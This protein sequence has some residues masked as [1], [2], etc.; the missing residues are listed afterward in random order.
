[1]DANTKYHP[2]FNSDSSETV[3]YNT[4]LFPAYVAYGLLSTYPDYSYSSHWHK[5][6]EFILVKK[7]T[8]T[9]NVNGRLIE[10]DENSGI[11]VNS[12]QLHYGF[13]AEHHE[14]E[15]VC[16]LLSPELLQI[17]DWFYQNF[18]EPFIENS[19]Y[20]Y[21]Y[22]NRSGWMASIM[23]KLDKIYDSFGKAPAKP[24]SYF[25]LLN[26]YFMIMETLYENLDIENQTQK[27]ESS[28]LSSLRSMMTY[29]EEH[30]MERIT[31]TDI[32]LSGACCK[33]KCSL[34]F[35]KY[36]RDTPIIYTT[37]LRLEKSLSTLLGSN[38]NISTI[39]YEYGFNGASYY[40]E[41]FKKYY[42]MPPLIYKKNRMEGNKESSE[43][44]K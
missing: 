11:L 10:L 27:P 38:S 25:E 22:L 13:S 2:V 39:A 7:G 19:A 32:A 43:Y 5:D 33:S 1:M 9:Y 17:N 26:D 30:Y 41:T 42:G 21:L 18:I 12:R 8:M 28:D 36:L 16:I 24:S 15:F 23:E 4:P 44:E 14:C 34:L 20:P 6:L 3:A 29:I 37:R 31:L 40:C 35:K